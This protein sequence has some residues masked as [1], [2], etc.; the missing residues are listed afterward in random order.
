MNKRAP[1]LVRLL[2]KKTLCLDLSTKEDELVICSVYFFN[3]KMYSDK[4]TIFNNKEDKKRAEQILL[5]LKDKY[6]II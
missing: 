2:G 4:I 1:L 5:E 6:N 3:K